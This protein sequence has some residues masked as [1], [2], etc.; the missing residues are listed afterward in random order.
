MIMKIADTAGCAAGLTPTIT[1][2]RVNCDLEPEYAIQY[3][4]RDARDWR[5]WDCAYTRIQAE[6]LLDFYNRRHRAEGREWRIA[7]ILY[8]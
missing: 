2:G 7:K 8:V 3:Y 4:S 5:V 6:N 1:A